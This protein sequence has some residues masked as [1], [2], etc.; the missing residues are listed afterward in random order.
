MRQGRLVL[1]LVGLGATCGALG[2]AGGRIFQFVRTPEILAV[3]LSPDETA[4]IR[5]IQTHSFSPEAQLAIQLDRFAAGGPAT[6][7]RLPEDWDW[8]GPAGTERFIWARDGTRVLLVG[9]HFFVRDDLLL[10]TGEEAYFLL[11]LESGRWWINSADDA[12]TREREGHGHLP[13]LTADLITG[14]EWTEPV[15]IIPRRKV[16]PDSSRKSE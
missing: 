10:A 3:R 7:A 2:F 8:G 1:V 4:R 9:R 11:D 13:T 16:D 15:A 6:V 14:I 12:M 5:L